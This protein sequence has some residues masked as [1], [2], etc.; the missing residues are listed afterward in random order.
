MKLTI[1][2]YSWPLE[3]ERLEA[4]FERVNQDLVVFCQC[5]PMREKRHLLTTACKV[6]S[7]CSSAGFCFAFADL[8]FF[9]GI[10]VGV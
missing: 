1:S 5:S 10:A 6:S 4:G 2:A 9:G 7:L 3:C 8:T